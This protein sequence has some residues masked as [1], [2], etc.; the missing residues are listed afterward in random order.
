M[1]QT[2]RIITAIALFAVAACAPKAQTCV[3]PMTGKSIVPLK[4]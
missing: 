3:K 4:R 1:N 2:I